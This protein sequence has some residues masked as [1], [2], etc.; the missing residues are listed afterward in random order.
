MYMYRMYNGTKGIKLFAEQSPAKRRYGVDRIAHLSARGT[1]ELLSRDA[2]GV[3]RMRRRHRSATRDDWND[4]E[5][6]VGGIVGS[7]EY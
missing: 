7:I 1:V 5:R 6:N 4:I 2:R 3:A